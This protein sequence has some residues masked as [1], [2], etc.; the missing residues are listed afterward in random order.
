MDWITRLLSPHKDRLWAKGPG[1]DFPRWLG[2][3][4]RRLLDPWV[5]PGL[6]VLSQKSE[7]ALQ[8]EASDTTRGQIRRPK[9]PQ[10]PAVTAELPAVAS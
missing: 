4:C 8:Q 9:I 1:E 2:D 3:L 5:V 10:L 6:C 7:I